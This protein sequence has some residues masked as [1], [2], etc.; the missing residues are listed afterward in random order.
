MTSS[1]HSLAAEWLRALDLELRTAPE[2]PTATALAKLQPDIIHYSLASSMLSRLPEGFVERERQ[3]SRVLHTRGPLPLGEA[4]S[5]FQATL[6]DYLT[7]RR[8]QQQAAYE[9]QKLQQHMASLAAKARLSR[10][11]VPTAEPE[12]Q[13]DTTNQ[14]SFLDELDA[15]PPP[16]TVES[17]VDQRDVELEQ[18]RDD[19]ARLKTGSRRLV[20]YVN[21]CFTTLLKIAPVGAT[22]SA[23]V[24]MQS[25]LPK[26]T[27]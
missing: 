9:K 26:L 18:L 17:V 19:F 6:A 2:P 12:V 8:E 23:I 20:E 25:K 11:K 22:R 10:K 24:E 3:G 16:P 1:D 14:T 27:S 4:I 15:V 5:Q 13:P 7:T 21:G